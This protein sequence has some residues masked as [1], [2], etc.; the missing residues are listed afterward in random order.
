MPTICKH[1]EK[2]CCCDSCEGD[3]RI[4]H[5]ECVEMAI[6]KASAESFLLGME[7][8][9]KVCEATAE[10][11]RENDDMG[12]ADA[13]YACATDIRFEMSKHEADGAKEVEADT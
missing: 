9:S 6:A 13:A 3:S 8:A 5:N 2:P 1:C 7:E 12:D 4:M 11:F 10:V